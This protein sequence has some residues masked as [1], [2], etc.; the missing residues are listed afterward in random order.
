MII[1]NPA[2]GRGTAGR[3]RAELEAALHAAGIGYDLVM[4]H[5]RGG[6]SE[7]AWQAA[8]KGYRQIVAVGGDGTINEVVNGIKGAEARSRNRPHLAVIP[9]GT[10][11]DFV[12]SLPGHRPNDVAGGV[13]RLAGGRLMSVDLGRVRVGK[14]KPGDRA[15]RLFINGLGMGV[16]AQVAA[17][18]LRFKRLKG[19]AA[20]VA[21]IPLGLMRYKAAPMQVRYDDRQFRGRLMF[22]SVASGRCQGGGFWFT[23]EADLGDGWLDMCAVDKLRLDQIVRYLPLVMRGKHTRLPEVTMGRARKFRVE[24]ERP[25]P[26]ATDGE[27]IATDARMVSVETLPDALKVIV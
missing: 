13:A 19:V 7:L 21:A 18:S 22:V 16:D 23:P 12:K 26:V 27:V 5:T 9:L 17:E 8:E 4:T 11:S 1:L 6:G 25:F 20:Y 10:G 3:K 15:D 2:A 14:L 24:G